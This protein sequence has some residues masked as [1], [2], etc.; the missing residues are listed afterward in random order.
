MKREKKTITAE[1]LVDLLGNRFCPPAWA[2]IPQVR[3]GTGFLSVTRTADA[4][5]MGLW[6][7]R[8]LHLNGFEIKVNRG[9][10]L[11]ELK[12]PDK[13]EEI[14]Q[15][16][17]FWWIVAPKDLIKVEE[18]PTPWGLMIPHGKTT[19]IIKQ[20]EQLE[21]IPIDKLFLAAI[22][23]RTQETITPQARLNAEFKEGEKRGK[24]KAQ[25]NF[26]YAEGIHKELEEKVAKFEKLSG[27]KIMDSWRV[28]DAAEAVKMVMKGEHLRVKQQ[29]QNLLTTA[30]EIAKNIEEQL[31][32][33]DNT[34]EQK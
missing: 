33:E 6:P 19:K 5:A 32:Q 2:F 13:A 27:V 9:D 34:K 17:D 28:E 31:S 1:D 3:N 26:E 4:I 12:R 15:F 30:K 22:L 16:C 18:L 23:R 7:S 25:Q 29:L 8:G 10:W 24:G 11:G 14:A 21:P 20:A